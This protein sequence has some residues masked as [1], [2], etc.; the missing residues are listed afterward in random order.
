MGLYHHT[1][2]FFHLAIKIEPHQF[3]CSLYFFKI[4]NVK[5]LISALVS[6]LFYLINSRSYI[7]M[8]VISLKGKF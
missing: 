8:G 2:H 1:Y 3:V 6:T 7:P 4:I 5:N